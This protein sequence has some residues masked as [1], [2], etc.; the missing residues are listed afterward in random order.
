MSEKTTLEVNART[1][2]NDAIAA[3]EAQEDARIKTEQRHTG[4]ALKVVS[5]Y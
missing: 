2:G 4:G 5:L 1:S 3:R